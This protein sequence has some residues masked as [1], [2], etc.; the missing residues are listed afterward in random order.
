M[1]ARS[2]ARVIALLVPV[3]LAVGLSGACTKLPGSLGASCLKDQDCQSGVCS[4]L[5]C[6]PS[7]P[8]LDAEV[9]NPDGSSDA[10]ADGTS[11]VPGDDGSADAPP[12]VSGDSQTPT[13]DVVQP[14]VDSNTP[15]D[16]PGPPPPDAQ[17]DAHPDASSVDAPADGTTDAPADAGE[18]G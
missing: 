17:E 9:P 11:T 4:Q 16:G 1:G 2:V 14:E 5:A 10:T 6:A 18:A 15:M 3:A 13:P 8:L 12:D 7:P